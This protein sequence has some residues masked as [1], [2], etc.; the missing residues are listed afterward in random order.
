MATKAERESK[1]K[2][3]AGEL[4]E[5]LSGGMSDQEAAEILGVSDG[6]LA[7]LKSQM[8]DLKAKE[9]HEATN[10]RTYLEY[11][12]SQ[13][14]CIADLDA[15]LRTAEKTSVT[16]EVAVIKTKSEIYDKIIKV[17]QDFGFIAKKPE[18]KRIIGGVVITNLDNNELRSAIA[19]E[20][21]MATKLVQ[22]HGDSGILDMDPGQLHYEEATEPRALPEPR[23]PK[24][25]Q[26]VPR[27]STQKAKANSLHKGRYVEKKPTLG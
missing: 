26:I 11:V 24:M 10:E 13:R 5:L 9:L 18:E 4:F 14:A 12:A 20:L 3:Q 19:K 7:A 27:S 21:G 16:Q 6:Q 8:W 23:K 22:Q 25:G 2:R 1:Q 17:G 15:S